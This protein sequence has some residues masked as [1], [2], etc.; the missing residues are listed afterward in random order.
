[1]HE[2]YSDD[3]ASVAVGDRDRLIPAGIRKFAGAAVFLGV[4]AAMGLW[5]YRLGTRDAAEVPVIRA[6]E[7]PARIQ[8]E[9]PGGA[10]AAHQGLEVN[11]VLSGTPAPMARTPVTP[12]PA[13]PALAEE[14]APQ[15]ALIVAAARAFA[16]PSEGADL[17]MPADDGIET[18]M[19]EE[20]PALLPLVAEA[21]AEAEPAAEA[22][23]EAVSD[24]RPRSRPGNLARVRA[25]QVAAATPAP[26]PVAAAPA[27]TV[28]QAREV[29][30][31]SRGSRLVQ[32]GA[33]DSEEIT[34]R[35][36]AQLVARHGDLLGSKSLYVERATSNSR[37][38]YRLRVAGFANTEQTRVMCESLRARGVDCIPVTL[39]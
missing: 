26:T 38:F 17:R 3:F 21:L 27:P 39:Q 4:V 25:P 13:R 16:E 8:P 30:S 34:R 11:A 5:S 7:G 2:A 12:A 28:A 31:I 19:V 36:W 23:A 32:L 10:Q 14:D 18:V 6:M 33:Y 35:A 1:M 24:Q 22:A 37:V 9:D 29:A 15:G 20:A